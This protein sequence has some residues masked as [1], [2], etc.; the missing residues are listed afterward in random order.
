ME[1]KKAQTAL[2]GWTDIVNANGGQ[3]TKD[4]FSQEVVGLA[5]TI[6][7]T[8]EPSV[9]QLQE[10]FESLLANAKMANGTNIWTDRQAI[11]KALRTVIK[12]AKPE[13]G[14]NALQ[15]RYGLPQS[16][17]EVIK[18]ERCRSLRTLA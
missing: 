9:V 5:K 6:Y 11:K 8:E 2:Q 10:A 18:I 12:T 15:N 4:A 3:I 17:T 1:L 16:K 14:Q 7:K 13:G